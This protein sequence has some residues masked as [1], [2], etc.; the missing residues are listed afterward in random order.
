[1]IETEIIYNDSTER[2]K[3][4]KDFNKETRT[5]TFY[6]DDK[7]MFPIDKDEDGFTEYI[8]TPYEL[9]GIECGDGWKGLIEPIM[10]YINNYNK[11]KKEEDKIIIFQ[12]KE[13]FGGLRFYVDHGNEELHNM[14]DKAEEESYKVCEFC[15]SKEDVG[16]TA[17]GWIT[18]LCH[19]CVKKITQEKE[20]PIRWRRNSDEKLYIVKFNEDDELIEK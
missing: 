17:N 11:D 3:A 6:L 14:I 1:M 12:I 8:P 5:V 15:G 19:N 20:V 9:F 18:T 4:Y 7:K 10:E 13:K 2:V 16:Q